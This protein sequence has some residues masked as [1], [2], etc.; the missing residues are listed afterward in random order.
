MWDQLAQDS[1]NFEKSK[2]DGEEAQVSDMVFLQEATITTRKFH[3]VHAMVQA[4]THKRAD[5]TKATSTEQSEGVEEAFN[6]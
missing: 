2:R 3:P 1:G 6:H 4:N 5:K